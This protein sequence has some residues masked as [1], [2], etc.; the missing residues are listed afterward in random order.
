MSK[1][2]IQTPYNSSYHQ[3]FRDICGESSEED[4]TG[5]KRFNDAYQAFRNRDI[6]YSKAKMDVKW[7]PAP[8]SS[9]TNLRFGTAMYQEQA[10]EFE[11]WL[12]LQDGNGNKINC[13]PPSSPA[14]I[15][16]SVPTPTPVPM[17][18][19]GPILFFQSIAQ[20][21]SLL[22]QAAY[23]LD[24]RVGQSWFG[25]GLREVNLVMYD[26]VNNFVNFASTHIEAILYA[27]AAGVVLAASARNGNFNTA[28]AVPMLNRSGQV[29]SRYWTRR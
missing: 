12:S 22:G 26:G 8:T 17:P 16:A 3:A 14:P 11:D 24:Q 4:N 18:R 10:R 9:S 2:P 6:P 20:S 23:D 13:P 28:Q 1:P 25:Q 27:G 21:L 19:K 7:R 5:F 29:L 15:S